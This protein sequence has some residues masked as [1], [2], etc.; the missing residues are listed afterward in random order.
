MSQNTEAKSSNSPLSTLQSPVAVVS[1][2]S[3]GLGKEFA[4]Q[5]AGE[6]FDLL[7][8]A[9]RENLLNEI[10]SDFE[11]RYG[12]N[13]EVCV[14]DLSQPDE[15]L[16]LEQRLEKLESI[17]YLV[18]NAGFGRQDGIYPQ[19]D[20]DHEEEMIRVHVVSL[21]RLTRA[22]LQPMCRRKKGYIINLSSVAAFIYGPGCVEYNAT[23][24]Y[25][26]SFS[27]SLQCDVRSYG[28]RV[29]ALCPGLT[30]TGFHA[31]PTMTGFK[32][33]K[34]PG[35]AWLTSEYVVRTSLR[36]IRRTGRVVC[37]PSLRYKIVLALFCNP[38]GNRICEAI[39]AKRLRSAQSKPHE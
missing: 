19:A 17:E 16:R 38:I 15:V 22:A 26:L 2:A 29:Q 4:R 21:M 32:K 5:L 31:T 13:V 18:N 35:I 23:K 1:G 24:S 7:L 28:V 12:V 39:Y 8:I 14:C 27:K 3:D 34:T 36:S 30:H 6:G 37:I 25:V 20:P 10:K 33:E 11:V 9:R